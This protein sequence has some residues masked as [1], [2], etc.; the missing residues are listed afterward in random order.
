M[1]CGSCTHTDTYVYTCTC[2]YIRWNKQPELV[3][4]CIQEI[5]LLSSN[6]TLITYLLHLLYLYTHTCLHSSITSYVYRRFTRIHIYAHKLFI[7][8]QTIIY[9]RYA[10]YFLN[11]LSLELL[12][13]ASLRQAICL[14]IFFLFYIVITI[15]YYDYCCIYAT[16]SHI[17]QCL[18]CGTCMSNDMKIKCPHNK[19]KCQWLAKSYRSGVLS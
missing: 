5:V 7:T 14:A 17:Q 13:K 15:L 9:I 11:S 3:N 2:K 8:C 1:S 12:S 4:I 6:I 19:S 16:I 18:R 10:T